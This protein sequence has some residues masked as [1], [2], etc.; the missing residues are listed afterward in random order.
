M[1]YI[2]IIVGIVAVVAATAIG[3]EQFGAARISLERENKLELVANVK[4]DEA[5]DSENADD[6][7]AAAVE[8]K[9][10]QIVFRS[11]KSNSDGDEKHALLI[12][13][14]Q[15]EYQQNLKAL[16]LN[17]QRLGTL[18]KTAPLSKRPQLIS[19]ARAAVFTGLVSDLFPAWYGTTWD[20]NGVTQS[21]GEGK[22]ACGYFVTT[23][24]RD[25]GFNLER[26]KLA[27]Q[28]SQTIIETVVDS[29]AVDTKIT[30]QKPIGD[31]A[32]A[33]RK[34]GHGIYIV[35]LDTHTGF[36]ANDGTSLAFVHSSYYRPPFS[37][38]A[39]PVLG[40]NPLADS[41]YRIVGKILGDKMI[42]KWLT[43]EKFEMKK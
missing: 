23:C 9:R 42:E 15:T 8:V 32:S 20:F 27:Q 12:S 35:G 39:E 5:G 16:S 19:E 24:L 2:S 14:K 6:E 30:Y 21:P 4:V 11:L 29:V 34:Q 41:K 28:P 31:I 1:K 18:W 37:V 13:K 26:I 22:I 43:G 33:I 17:Q 10:G 38:T 36:V 25:A 3:L 7:S 40:V